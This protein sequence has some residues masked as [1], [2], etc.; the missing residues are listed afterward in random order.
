MCSSDL[1]PSHDKRGM[2]AEG[3]S[4]RDGRTTIFDY[5]HVDTLGRWYHQGKMG[6]AL[7]TSEEQELQQ[8]Y[9]TLLNACLHEKALSKGLFFD[10]MYANMEGGGLDPHRQ[11]VFLRAYEDEAVLV[12]ANFSDQARAVA[13][14]LPQHAF[15]Y[16]HLAPNRQCEAVDLLT[17]ETE[18]ICV[19]PD[20][21]VET[22]VAPW[23]GKLLKFK[24]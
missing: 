10:L 5:W 20:Q 23:G 16:L 9:S 17:N 18:T 11:Y 1:F 15:D 14:N 6:H 7:L 2:D 13:I 19:S 21:P 8:F 22:Y 3:F 12:I 4:G 24:H